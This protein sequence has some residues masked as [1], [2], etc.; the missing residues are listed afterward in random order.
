VTEVLVVGHDAVALA[1]AL[2]LARAGMEVLQV[3][4]P[5][6]SLASGM[7]PWPA[8]ATLDRLGVLDDL[9]RAGLP[10]RHRQL[11]VLATGECLTFDLSVLD[12]AVP[13][14]Y[15][16][17][18]DEAGLRAV[19]QAHLDR[20]ST[21]QTLPAN[22]V[23]RLAQDPD[24]V[25]LELEQDDEIVRRRTAWLVAADG[26][27]SVVRRMVGVGFPGTTWQERYVVARL[28]HDFAG[29]AATTLQ[30]DP[31]DGAVLRQSPGGWG[32]AYVEPL[33]LAEASTGDRV[34][35]TLARVHPAAAETLQSWR[36]GRMHER[37]ASHYRIGRV[38]LA[39]DAAHATNVLSDDGLIAG[40]LDAE[41]LVEALG[42][43]VRG[44]DESL[45]DAYSE[46]R[47]RDFLDRVLPASVEHKNLITQ[48]S[49]P[50]R[51]DTELEVYRRAA[52]DP[53]DLRELLLFG[54]QDLQQP[55]GF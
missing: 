38:V 12:G 7:V 15:D 32:Y 16:V 13:H 11:R 37:T 5:A 42:A 4:T 10:S 18:C 54:H 48:I 31:V 20:M 52:A 28:D 17:G 43:V 8:L 45:L 24:G 26:T 25:V 9:V 33:T 44:A 40:L 55:S 22:R 36:S 49:D 51:L 1:T 19:L 50:G 53:A 21:V 29:H 2:G 47:R 27:N 6:A 39:G 35:Q 14:P 23:L 30:V 34:L 41:A 3:R 46:V